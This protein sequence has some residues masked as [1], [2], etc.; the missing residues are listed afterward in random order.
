MSLSITTRGLN[1]KTTIFE[2]REGKSTIRLKKHFVRLPWPK[3]PQFTFHTSTDSKKNISALQ[4]R[5]IAQMLDLCYVTI[6]PVDRKGKE[7]TSLH[8]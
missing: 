1:F 5:I 7:E 8:D 2:Q 6:I 4:K 3:A